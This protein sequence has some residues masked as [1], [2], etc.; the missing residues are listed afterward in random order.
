VVRALSKS[1][2]DPSTPRRHALGVALRY[3]LQ[4]GAAV[5]R[6]D[7]VSTPKRVERIGQRR[8]T[9]G[10]KHEKTISV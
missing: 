8:R 10:G 9:T 2:N 1:L 6:G 5:Q 7:A 4:S 3:R